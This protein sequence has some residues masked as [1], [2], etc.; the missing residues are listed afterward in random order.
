MTVTAAMLA[1][2]RR[3]VAEP[4]D[5]HGY[6]DDTLSA[7]LSEYPLLDERG[8]EPY[9]WDT[10]STP[11]TQDANEDWVARYDT[12]AAASQV[13]EEKA[14]E[15]A[16]LYDFSAD[17]GRYTRS[18]MF[19]QALRMAR[20][21]NSRRAPRTIRAFTWPPPSRNDRDVAANHLERDRL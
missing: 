4:D 21:H 20:Y 18:Q 17:G 14:T 1:T 13:W 10:A 15:K 2:L 6:D 3:M 9:T 7:I 19:E 8:E 16:H 12:H 5:A 11:P